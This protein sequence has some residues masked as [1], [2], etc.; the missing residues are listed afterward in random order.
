MLNLPYIRV[1]EKTGVSYAY[2]YSSHA[3]EHTHTQT[4]R[5]K[6]DRELKTVFWASAS[7]GFGALGPAAQ[8]PDGEI[9]R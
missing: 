7:A 4:T 8:E 3:Q 1:K 6:Q 2:P 5:R 9:N